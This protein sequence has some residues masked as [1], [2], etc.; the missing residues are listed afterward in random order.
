MKTE[1]LLYTWAFKHAHSQNLL[2]YLEFPDA[3]HPVQSDL[4]P[5]KLSYQKQALKT[6]KMTEIQHDW[7]L[8][9]VFY[10][11]NDLPKLTHLLFS[12]NT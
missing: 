1:I 8:G 9:I 7:H 10:I 5:P 12:N 6:Y 11:T 3:R 4:F 2:T